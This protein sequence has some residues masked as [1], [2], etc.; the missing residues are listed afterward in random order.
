MLPA[1]SGR[2][3]H[4]R[5]GGVD[6]RARDRHE[7]VAA[8]GPEFGEAA[9]GISKQDPIARSGNRMARR[10]S[11]IS[12][13]VWDRIDKARRAHS[14]TL[15]LSGQNLRSIPDEIFDFAD[16]DE[17][18][19][20]SNQLHSLPERMRQLRSRR[21]VLTDN[22]IESLPDIPGLVLDWDAYWRCRHR[23]SKANIRGIWL[24]LVP[25]SAGIPLLEE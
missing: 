8:G 18:Y 2:V 19:L 15:D 17:L 9:E 23:V 24:A 10:D 22:P 11:K 20:N 4:R 5:V 3:E 16:L 25:P 1:A 7:A 6:G 12:S 13:R 21:L 14:R